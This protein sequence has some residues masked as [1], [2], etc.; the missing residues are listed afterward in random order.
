LVSSAREGAM[1]QQGMLKFWVY[2]KE[3]QTRFSGGYNA[4]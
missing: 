1:E 3:K 4:H 2:L